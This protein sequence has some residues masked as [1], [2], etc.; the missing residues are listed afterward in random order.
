M[1]SIE[2]KPASYQPTAV[3]MPV[4]G[5][6][7]TTVVQ[8]NVNTTQSAPKAADMAVENSINM[9]R[10]LD[11]AVGRLNTMLQQNDRNLAFH[12]DDKLGR[13]IVVLRKEDTGEVVRQIPSETVVA[14]AHYL[15]D[16]KGI[17]HNQTT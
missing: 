17:L 11:D 12:V 2:F 5:S 1:S 14:I 16:L 10:T 13:P 15:E 6:A 9:K 3:A 8:V 4:A 7:P